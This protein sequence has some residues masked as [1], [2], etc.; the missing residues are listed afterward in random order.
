[1]PKNKKRYALRGNTFQIYKTEKMSNEND[2]NID[3]FS[4]LPD[5]LQI[6]N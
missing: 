3:E 5:I 6:S 1:M 2:E 4:Q